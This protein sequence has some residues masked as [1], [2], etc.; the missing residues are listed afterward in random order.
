MGHSAEPTRHECGRGRLE[1]TRWPALSSAPAIAPGMPSRGFFHPEVEDND[2]WAARGRGEEGGGPLLP[3]CPPRPSLH[4]SLVVEGAWGPWRRPAPVTS[5]EPPVLGGRCLLDVF[6]GHPGLRALGLWVVKQK[7]VSFR[8]GL[9]PN[10]TSEW[11]VGTA[12]PKPQGPEGA[13]GAFSDLPWAHRRWAGAGLTVASQGPGLS[14]TWPLRETKSPG[15]LN[16]VVRCPSQKQLAASTSPFAPPGRVRERGGHSCHRLQRGGAGPR[17]AGECGEQWDRALRGARGRLPGAAQRAAGSSRCPRGLCWPPARG[18]IVSV[19]GEAANR[20]PASSL[21]QKTR[22]QNQ[23]PLPDGLGLGV[24]DD[25]SVGDL[26]SGILKG[27]KDQFPE[28]GNKVF[29]GV[30]QWRGS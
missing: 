6:P 27:P 12:A 10:G 22:L 28:E 11:T 29:C 18:R 19:E 4:R 13:A 17:G 30:K 5:R 2:S 25:L 3:H 7:P 16:L 1:P 21:E 23:L 8:A 14:G 9:P 26:G 24:E 15:G 20:G